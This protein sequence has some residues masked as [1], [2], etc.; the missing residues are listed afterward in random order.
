MSR[1]LDDAALNQLFCSARTHKAWLDKPVTRQQIDALYEL[2][3]WGPTANNSVPGRFVFLH[4]ADARQRLQPHLS[5]GNVVKTMSATLTVF[6][7]TDSRFYDHMPRLAPHA[8]DARERFAANPE[9]AWRTAHR[10]GT[11]QG[12][13]LIL[14]ARALGLDC[15]PMSGFDAEG[16]DAEFFADGRWRSNFL[17]NIG[18]GDAEAL[19]PR[20]VR[21]DF[22][23]ACQL[24]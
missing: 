21:L 2:L 9:N 23:E 7:A 3:K 13:Y 20:A 6:I 19:H 17:C 10:N 18:Y 5:A 22:D 1:P 16:V 11:L 8:G 4:S 15:G 14:A 12:A 24:L